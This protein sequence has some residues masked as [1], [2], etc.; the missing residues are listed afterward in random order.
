MR[1]HWMCVPAAC[2]ALFWGAAHDASAQGGFPVTAAF[3]V[4]VSPSFQGGTQNPV[5]NVIL[6]IYE[7]DPGLNLP[8]D[9]TLWNTV[10]GSNPLEYR[11]AMRLA[12]N[13]GHYPSE[14][15]GNPGNKTWTV[16]VYVLDQSSYQLSW[17]LDPDAADPT[18][19]LPTNDQSLFLEGGP[20]SV[21]LDMEQVATIPARITNTSGQGRVDT[22][23]I[24]LAR[25]PAIV[26]A[27][28]DGTTEIDETGPTNDTY[29]VSLASPPS[30]NVDVQI[31]YDSDQVS[32]SGDTDGTH[33][34]T[35]T[36]ANYSSPV[37]VTVQAVDDNVDEASPHSV[38]ITHVGIS[39]DPDYSQLAGATVNVSITDNDTA[40]LQIVQTGGTTEVAENGGQDTLDVTLAT[41]P[42]SNV[43]LTV[44]SSDTNQ[45]TV[46]PATLTFTPGDYDQAQ[47]VTVTG[48][49]DSDIG[50]QNGTVTI[51]VD[52][53][54]S[55][56]TYD[57]LVDQQVSVT[58]LDDDDV[59]RA[60]HALVG[61]GY[62]PGQTVDVTC[63]FGHPSA[64][65]VLGLVWQFQLPTGWTLDSVQSVSGGGSP[66]ESA[67][68]GEE[69][70]VLFT[71]NFTG[72]P[73]VF[74]GTFNVPGDAS[75]TY[76]MVS[77]VDYTLSGATGTGQINATPDPLQISEA[78]AT[79]SG[80]Y[81]GNWVISTLEANRVLIYWR[82]GAY[83][84]SAGQPDGFLPGA[85]DQ[86]GVPHSADYD[87]NWVISTLE[88]NRVLIYWRAGAYH[89]DAGQP[90]GFLPG[91]E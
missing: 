40:A 19:F 37:T 55:D 43:V 62:T 61:R 33:T 27:P 18:P 72:N 68:Q 53:A 5:Q 1:A 16:E 44:Q 66:E 89:A 50:N 41:E 31:T 39:G 28:S 32:V 84:I 73:V 48:V 4:E 88:A 29:D 54:Q 13:G 12:I 38:N 91:P 58:L 70:M 56:D 71:G 3:T 34:V 77:L 25:D 22:Y 65:N 17:T 30:Q 36:P 11:N 14:S 90:D 20:G 2:I 23:T 64:E 15:L 8:P 9:E 78:P 7:Q 80:D 81:D 10:P 63:E 49:N 76:S 85:G 87:G 52:D 51:S 82:A 46:T 57:P 69:G 59:L 79:H 60:S 42:T 74:T 45:L 35:F 83:H 21:D 86:N 26:I 6:D 24:T 67:Q 47:T 75:N